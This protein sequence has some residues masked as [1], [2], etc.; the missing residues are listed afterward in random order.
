[1]RVTTQSPVPINAYF[2]LESQGSS[3]P[4]TVVDPSACQ[5][6]HSFTPAKLVQCTL[7][8]ASSGIS[9]KTLEKLEKGHIVIQLLA[10]NLA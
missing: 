1:M 2:Y 4:F 3:I 7:T 10:V 6:Y 5:L 9:I 8:S